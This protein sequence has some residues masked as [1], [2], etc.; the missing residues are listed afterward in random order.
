MTKHHMAKKSGKHPL[1][2]CWINIKCRC[3]NTNRRCYKDYGGRG[4]KVHPSWINDF[5]EFYNWSIKNNW[6]QGL[7]IDRID[8]D[9]DYEPNNCQWVTNL[10]QSRNKRNSL[11]V[12]FKNKTQCASEWEKELNYPRG[13]VSG[14]L[15][16]GWTVEK[17]LT[18]P[19]LRKHL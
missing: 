4:I 5:Q 6:K 17:T 9:G 3:Y 19:V 10:E 11:K 7:T 14:R 12:T 18:T 1:Y 13:L 2:V 8:V 16:I 15:R